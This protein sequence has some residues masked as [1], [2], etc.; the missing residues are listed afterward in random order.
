MKNVPAFILETKDA[1]QLLLERLHD[2]NIIPI[3]AFFVASVY[4]W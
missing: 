1:C 3:D 4:F 2:Q